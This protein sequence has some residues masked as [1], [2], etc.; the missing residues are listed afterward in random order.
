MKSKTKSR[1][2][3]EFSRTH[4]SISN[5]GFPIIHQLETLSLPSMT[6]DMKHSCYLSYFALPMGF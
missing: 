5:V 2:H 1:K 4:V 6:C 3:A